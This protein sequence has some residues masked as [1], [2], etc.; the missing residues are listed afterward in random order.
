MRRAA[1]SA[2]VTRAARFLWRK[3]Q[4]KANVMRNWCTQVLEGLHYLHTHSP[5][6]WHRGLRCET[7]FISGNV[8]IVKI[9]VLE[10]AP[11]LEHLAPPEL[12]VAPVSPPPPPPPPPPAS[13]TRRSAVRS[14]A[15][16]AVRTRV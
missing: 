8:S 15:R 16:R 5:P 2:R 4:M 7:V 9:G 6:L 1:A 13:A 3:V 10:M 11:L 14:G 12:H